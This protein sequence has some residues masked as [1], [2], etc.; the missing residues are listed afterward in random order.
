MSLELSFAS[1]N[2][3][4]QFAYAI[5]EPC[6]HISPINLKFKIDHDTEISL[7]SDG[8]QFISQYLTIVAPILLPKPYTWPHG[9]LRTVH[10]FNIGDSDLVVAPYAEEAGFASYSHLIRENAYHDAGINLW[11]RRL[12]PRVRHTPNHRTS[13]S[14]S[15]FVRPEI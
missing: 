10:N 7:K 8:G 12:Q 15:G 11:T 13:H 14:T 6:K 3:F 5:P 9:G 4:I 1:K 2:H